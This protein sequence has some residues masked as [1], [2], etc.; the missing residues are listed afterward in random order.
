MKKLLFITLLA[1]GAGLTGCLKDDDTTQYYG[2]G[3]VQTSTSGLLIRSDE[4]NLI[5]GPIASTSEI[6][7]GDRLYFIATLTR[8]GTETD[9]YD[10]L[11]KWNDL[12]KVTTK[13]ILVANDVNRDTVGNDK[14]SINALWI[15]KNFLNGDLAYAHYNKPHYLSLVY[16]QEKQTESGTVILELKHKANGDLTTY[17]K[18][19]IISFNLNSIE[20]SGTPPHKIKIKY[21]DYTSGEIITLERTYTPPTGQ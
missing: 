21:N 3:I 19:G 8:K 12:Y 14:L 9:N 18:R 13:N 5:Y 7:V 4:D 16:D 20:W 10:Y 11:V 2:L 6:A 15:S 17:W 1:L